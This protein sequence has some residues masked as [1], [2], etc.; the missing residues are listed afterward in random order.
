M[1]C[2]H[3]VNVGQITLWPVVIQGKAKMENTWPFGKSL[4]RACPCIDKA[5]VENPGM[6][7]LLKDSLHPFQKNE[8]A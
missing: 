4:M 3:E 2:Y 6:R 7:V 5:R 8:D 1:L